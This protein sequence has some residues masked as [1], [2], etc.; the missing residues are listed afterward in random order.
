MPGIAV[1]TGASRGIG[2]A[3]AV[4]LARDGFEVWANYRSRDD[5]A[6]KLAEEVRALGGTCKLLKFDVADRAAAQ[7]ALA[8]LEETPA[9][10]LVNNAGITKD[11]L[12]MTMSPD[13]W[14]SVLTTNLGAFYNVTRPV[15]KG[16]AR[17]RAGRIVSL[18]SVS[19]QHGNK[20]QANYAASKAGI[21]AASKSL[22][23]E[24][25]RWSILVNVVAPGFIETDMVA[26]L[27][28]GELEKAVP[29]RRFGRPE[30][31]ASVV[32]F[33]ASDRASYITGAVIDVNGGLY[34]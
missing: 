8:P 14:S 31:V 16:M 21:I 30:E 4:A 9:A 29:L 3:C 18:A 13:D 23:L 25:G 34:T 33:L 24:Y 12:F 19:G 32:S 20:G 17:A 2:R 10:V 26:G 6:E 28:K 22:A 5:E 1:V 11:G 27:P 7:E 15:L